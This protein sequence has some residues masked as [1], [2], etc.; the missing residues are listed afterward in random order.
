M[1]FEGFEGC[2]GAGQKGF[3]SGFGQTRQAPELAKSGN[4]SKSPKAVILRVNIWPKAVA[5]CHGVSWTGGLAGS[6]QAVW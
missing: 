5:H 4:T 1:V 6:S 2:V 3:K